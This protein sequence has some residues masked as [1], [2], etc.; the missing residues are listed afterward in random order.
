MKIQEKNYKPRGVLNIAKDFQFPYHHDPIVGENYYAENVF[1]SPS[2]A[3]KIT[4]IVRPDVLD[5]ID[6]LS[7]KLKRLSKSYIANR[8]IITANELVWH[9]IPRRSKTK[10]NKVYP[11]LKHLRRLTRLT[12]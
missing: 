10:R 12:K 1:I 3:E 5:A 9:S 6:D 4:S 7:I 2:D 11:Y 8:V